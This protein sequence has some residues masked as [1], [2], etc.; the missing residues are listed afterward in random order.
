[1]SK[2]A[3]NHIRKTFYFIYN[4]L[5]AILQIQSVLHYHVLLFVEIVWMGN[6]DSI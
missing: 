1:M 4:L 5:K 2:I 3:E 6:T